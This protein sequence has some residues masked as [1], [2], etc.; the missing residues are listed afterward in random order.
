M[1]RRLVLI[2]SLV[3]VLVSL[4]WF[5]ELLA[6]DVAGLSQEEKKALLEDFAARPAEDAG[7]AV[8]R[9]PEIFKA[10]ERKALSDS[11]AAS[12]TQPS[13]PTGLG[14]ES[15]G[16]GMPA[17]DDLRP[18]GMELFRGEVENELPIDIPSAE[19]YVLGPGDNLVIYLWGRVEKQYVLTIDREGK[20]FVPQVGEMVAWGLTLADFVEAARRQFSKAYSDFDLTVS[21]GKVRSIRIF[22]AGEVRRPGAYT[23]S[24]L[25]SLFNA[26]Y[27]AGGPNERGS[28]RRIKLMRNGQPKT[29]VDVYNLLLKGDNSADVRLQSGDVIFVPVSGARV[30]VRGE[31]KRAALYELQGDERVLDLIALAGSTTAE[32][33]LERV[34]LERVSP[35]DE[36]Q[37]LDLDLSDRQAEAPDNIALLDGDRVTVYSIFQAKKNIVAVFGQVKHTGYYERNDSTHVSNVL[38]RAQLKPYDVFFERADLFRRYPDRRAEV[39]PIDLGAVLSGDSRADVLLQDRDSLHVYS[40]ADVQWEKHVY[41]EGEVN[42]PGRYPLYD[43]MAVEDLVF[44]AGSYKRG[45]YRQRVEIARLDSVGGVSVFYVDLERVN[46]R[47]VRLEEDD[48][49]YVRQIP[50]WQD[51]WSVAVEGEVRYPGKYALSGKG[52]TLYQILQRVGGFTDK[53]FPRGTVVERKSICESLKRQRI[54]DIIDNTLTITEDSLGRPVKDGMVK[55]DNRSM[56]RLII[57]MDRILATSG[58]EADVV[59]EPGDRIHVPAIPSGISVIG[60][61]GSNGTIRYIR[62]K[63]VRYYVERA[64]NFTRQADKKHARLVRATGEVVSG[65]G[66]LGETV[67]L[68]DVIIVPSRIEKD[69][70]WLKAMTTALGAA[71]GVLTSVYIISKL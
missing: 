31:I 51:E 29:V 6:Q 4:N 37:V 59:L 48:H 46:P 8:Y 60:A 24:S 2:L 23:V 40:I 11:N 21:L 30:A 35:K 55:F 42:N 38:R 70:N 3:I 45:A 71:T 39:I 49:V 26:L 16:D 52:E 41:I 66:T 1:S 25:T 14:P 36:W 68:G 7:K 44:L 12:V 47:Q 43:D 53:A 50:Q 33:H 28:M 19:D 18:F 57:D 56:D 65:R 63:S 17:F 15:G 22:I 64:G 34:M 62:N 10:D 9:S 20:V 58:R 13:S 69:K 61:V 27:L 54:R 5:Q 67:D 32:A